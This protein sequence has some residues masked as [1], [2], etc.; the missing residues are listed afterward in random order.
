MWSYFEQ[1]LSIVLGLGFRSL[2]LGT[3]FHIPQNPK[4]N[5]NKTLPEIS[6]IEKHARRVRF[7]CH[8]FLSFENSGTAVLN[9]HAYS[10]LEQL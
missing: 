3:L 9:S 4:L 1:N 6:L 7:R 10:A 2:G 8:C 5:P